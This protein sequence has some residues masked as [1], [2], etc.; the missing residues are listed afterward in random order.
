MTLR[1]NSNRPSLLNTLSRR[2]HVTPLCG[3]YHFLSPVRCIYIDFDIDIQDDK[4]LADEILRTAPKVDMARSLIVLMLHIWM[5]K[6]MLVCV[7]IGVDGILVLGWGL[8]L[9]GVL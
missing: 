7:C 1:K 6:T 4:L 3:P 8:H 9:I 5:C 2:L